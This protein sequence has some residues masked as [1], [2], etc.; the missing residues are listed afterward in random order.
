MKLGDFMENLLSNHIY[1][2]RCCRMTTCFNK[3]ENLKM[4]SFYLELAACV[5]LR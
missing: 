4:Y 2:D 1:E 3:I 5:N